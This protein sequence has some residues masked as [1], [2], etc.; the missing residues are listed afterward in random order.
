MMGDQMASNWDLKLGHFEGPGAIWWDHV[1]IVMYCV[2]SGSH[3]FFHE[4]NVGFLEAQRDSIMI[5]V[6]EWCPTPI[7]TQSVDSL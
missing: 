1:S 7:R 5:I 2:F 6:R 4:A 3:H